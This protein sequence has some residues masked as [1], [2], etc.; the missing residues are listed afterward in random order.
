M[1]ADICR[2]WRGE[3]DAVWMVDNR[4]IDDLPLNGRNIYGLVT[5][6]PGVATDFT[7]NNP[8]L[9]KVIRSV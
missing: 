4:R 8:I 9:P 2:W 5:L 3:R 7:F 6:L 1:T